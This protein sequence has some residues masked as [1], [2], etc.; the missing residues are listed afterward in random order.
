MHKTIFCFICK[1]SIEVND[2]R[3]IAKLCP[4]HDTEEN[5]ETM[6]NTPTRQLLGI[7]DEGLQLLVEANKLETNTNMD[8]ILKAMA[9]IKA[10]IAALPTEPTI[11]QEPTPTDTNI[12]SGNVNEFGEII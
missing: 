11:I 2:G 8:D 9:D 12:Q 5:R 3:A 7:Q 10:Q 1:K 4:E 6:V